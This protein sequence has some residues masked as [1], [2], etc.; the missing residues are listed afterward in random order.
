MDLVP[1]AG[2]ETIKPEAAT[3]SPIQP[4][5][6]PNS[7]PSQPQKRRRRRRK[8]GEPEDPDDEPKRRV[9][10]TACI[11]CRKRKSKCDGNT[12]ACAACSQVYNTPCIYDPNSDHRRKGV[13][14]RDIEGLKTKES[15]LQTIVQAILNYPEDEV[16]DLVQQI[17]T[18]ESLDDV[19]EDIVA[20]EYGLN[21]QEEEEDTIE[22]S[23]PPSSGDA[24]NFESKLGIKMAELRL[25][26][27]SVRY[28]GG[29]SHLLY[30]NALET[31]ESNP[32]AEQYNQ[33]QQNP[34]TS[35]TTVTSDQELVTHLLD[36]Y[37]TWHYSFFTCLSRS[38]FYRDFLRGRQLEDGSR[39]TRYCSALLVNVMLALGCHFTNNPAAREDPADPKTVGNH[40]FREAKRLLVDNDEY[41][42]PK[43]TTV[44]ALA[45]MSVREAGCGREAKG[46]LYSGVSL[47]LAN[48]MGLHLDSGTI[49][50][51]ASKGP[52]EAEEDARRVTFWGCFFFDKCWS[53]YLGRL[54]Q[55][56]TSAASCP[57]YDVFPDEDGAQWIPYS[58][59]GT[60]AAHAQPARTRAVGLQISALGEISGDLM[61][62]F[63][64]PGEVVDIHKQK[65]K[66]A[67]LKKLSEIQIRLEGW[68]KNL[69]KEMEPREGALASVFI[70]Q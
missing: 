20:R 69:P 11:A 5:S 28:I 62:Y 64:N 30:L 25:N 54:P 66:Q 3:T 33:S 70:M 44:Q 45:L 58:D 14:K 7:T 42:S 39:K 55:L 16:P 37:F 35:W 6:H 13:Y 34:I 24:A 10:T 43:L 19:A 63:Y 57:K 41:E 59:I 53:N 4:V 9:V 46:W 56:P 68:R 47:R 65:S 61:K 67:E 36:V 22:P 26:D 21:K 17:R 18:C 31:D 8:P 50:G 27:G 2:H 29:T 23:S 60:T 51:G 32:G 49:A 52:D 15:T 12:P 48:E 1:T 40:F 38:L